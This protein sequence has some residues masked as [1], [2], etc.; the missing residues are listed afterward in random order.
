VARLLGSM[1]SAAAAASRRRVTSGAEL[2]SMAV[3]SVGPTECATVPILPRE[4]RGTVLVRAQEPEMLD[5]RRRMAVGA[6]ARLRRND[7]SSARGVGDAQLAPPAVVEEERQPVLWAGALHAEARHGVAGQGSGSGER[8]ER[9]RPE[10]QRRSPPAGTRLAQA[11]TGESRAGHK[12]CEMFSSAF[13][14]PV[15]FEGGRAVTGTLPGMARSMSAIRCLTALD[16]VRNT[17]GDPMTTERTTRRRSAVRWLVPSCSPW[18][19]SPR[20]MR[21]GV[22]GTRLRGPR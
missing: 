9:R 18:R 3:Q 19:W 11:L 8:S 22:T 2:R 7:P 16:P 21:E 15:Q 13:S 20:R 17:H 10:R 12:L 1:L 5:G 6:E 4:S 14:P